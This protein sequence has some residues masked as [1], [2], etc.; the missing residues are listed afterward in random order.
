MRIPGTVAIVTGGARGLGKAFSEELL[1]RGG[2]VCIADVN[3]TEGQQTE[4][5]F[6]QKYGEDTSMFMKCDITNETD[7]K[8]LWKA[9]IKK[10]KYVDLMVNN[11]GILNEQEPNKTVEINLLGVMRGTMIAIEHMRKDRGGKGG[12]IINVSSTA[13]LFPVFFMPSY[14]ASK[15]GVVGFTR[16]WAANPL[17]NE[18]GLSFA[19][20][21]PAFSDT[22][23]L[24]DTVDVDEPPLITY[25][26]NKETVDG[27]IGGL[28]VNT[29][30][31]V[32]NAFVEL[33]ENPDNNGAVVTVEKKRGPRY[34]F[35]DHPH[36]L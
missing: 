27:I 6:K 33:V 21:C 11:A 23:M 15:Y 8:G 32:T 17:V 5:I 10:F 1:K 25:K 18:F 2:K 12:L 28:G 14:A 20:L 24:T 22:N 35:K 7:F 29:V 3:V 9:A 34:R 4:Q 19:C 13:G 26:Q 30:E 31:D 16:S 36:K